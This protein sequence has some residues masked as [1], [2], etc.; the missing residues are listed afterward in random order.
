M[1][2]RALAVGHHDL[3]ADFE[4]PDAFVG[5]HGAGDEESNWLPDAVMALGDVNGDGWGDLAAVGDLDGD[6]ASYG[7]TEEPGAILLLGIGD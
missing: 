1:P 3:G 4:T 5:Y 6:G 2:R 7:W